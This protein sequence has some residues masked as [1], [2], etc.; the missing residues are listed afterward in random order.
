MAASYSAAAQNFDSLMKIN[1]HLDCDDIA[2]SSALLFENYYS[3]NKTDSVKSVLAYWE[4]KC[5]YREP[6]HRAKL[7]LALKEMQYQDSLLPRDILFYVFNYQ[8]RMNMVKNHTYYGYD[9]YKSYYGYVPAG[10]EYDMFTIKEFGRL[11]SVYDTG[12]VEYLLCE[13]YSDN[14]DTLFTKLQT[15]DYG[16]STLAVEYGK[17]LRKHLNMLETHLSLLTGVW[18]PAGR[19][20]LLG[21]HPELGGQAGIKYK[22]MSYD[23]T[24]ALKFVNSPNGY[25]AKRKGANSP[26]LTSHFF[27]GY[28]GIDVG[29]D[30]YTRRKHNLQLAGGIAVDGF[31]ALREDKDLNLKSASVLS[32][33]FNLGFAYRY[34]LANGRYIGLKAKYNVVD[35]TLNSVVDLTGNA[36]TVHFTFGR[37]T[38]TLKVNNLKALKY[39]EN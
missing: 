9:E 11:K 26:E 32:Y 21:V 14:Y 8:N 36:I 24:I 34:Y 19:L 27:G 2:Y 18:M 12:T 5:G 16:T 28:F 22:K 20:K 10:K 1:R 31:D 6:V 37:H 30:I 35:Y 38:N 13:F 23:L 17:A 39:R 3:A 33:N 29:R 15:N 25:Y 4:D 7:L